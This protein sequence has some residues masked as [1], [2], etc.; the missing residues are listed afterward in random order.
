MSMVIFVRGVVPMD[1]SSLANWEAYCF[2]SAS[3]LDSIFGF[4]FVA[5][6]MEGVW[7]YLFCHNFLKSDT[8]CGMSIWLTFG[9]CIISH[10]IF[11][12]G[13]EASY[14]FSFVKFNVFVCVIRHQMLTDVFSF[15]LWMLMI[16]FIFGS[17]PFVESS[18]VRK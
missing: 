4:S 6:W 8:F 10:D 15:M 3:S 11:Y 14:V 17:L 12:C 18:S 9:M 2:R 16:M 1:V 5:R 13:F 7:V